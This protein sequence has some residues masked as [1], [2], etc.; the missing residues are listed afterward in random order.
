MKIVLR[1][2]SDKITDFCKEETLDWLEFEKF[3]NS[4]ENFEY[5][6]KDKLLSF[7]KYFFL[8]HIVTHDKV[9]INF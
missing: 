7:I 9:F 2:S 5:P 8:D 6:H 3:Y 4:L 1:D